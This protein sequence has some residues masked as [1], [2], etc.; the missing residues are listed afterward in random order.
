MPLLC[1]LFSGLFVAGLL[2]LAIGLFAVF[3]AVRGPCRPGVSL[4]PDGYLVVSFGWCGELRI[5][6]GSIKSVKR[7]E[8]PGKGFRL[9]GITLP[10]LRTG[11]YRFREIGSVRVYAD[12]LRDLLLVETI[13]GDKFL[14]GFGTAKLLDGLE[15]LAGSGPRGS[16]EIRTRGGQMALAG[17]L[18]TILGLVVLLLAYPYMA[19]YSVLLGSRADKADLLV[20]GLV[21]GLIGMIDP[22]LL[23]G[24]G[25]DNPLVPLMIPF[26]GLGT[27]LV[28]ASIALI[29]LFCAI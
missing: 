4:S 17:I 27:L 28:E 21:I 9:V 26:S 15:E 18:L 20:M 14:L 29:G 8:D 2:S 16:V 25:S 23:Y 12:K 24:L 19:T 5:P 22:V 7:I 10:G 11:D 6:I 3:Y 13:N 1:W